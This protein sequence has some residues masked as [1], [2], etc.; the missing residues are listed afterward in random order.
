MSQ[1]QLQKY[2]QLYITTYIVLKVKN[3]ICIV[4]Y[5]TLAFVAT[6]FKRSVISEAHNLSFGRNYT[7]DRRE[8]V[9]NN[10][11]SCILLPYLP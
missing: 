5:E 2:N 10:N 4:I 1:I 3:N 7:K 8:C 11:C 6:S 9:N